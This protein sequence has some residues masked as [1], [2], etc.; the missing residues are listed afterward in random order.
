MNVNVG[1]IGW[2][3]FRGLIALILW[4]I[5]GLAISTPLALLLPEAVAFPTGIAGGF[6][7]TFA[8]F[9]YWYFRK[10]PKTE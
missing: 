6:I 1:R 3:A 5:I 2:N 8:I 4:Q 10:E 7:L 9:T